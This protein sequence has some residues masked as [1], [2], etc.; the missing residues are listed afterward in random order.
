MAAPP[1]L[2]A[3]WVSAC[4]LVYADDESAL[5]GLARRVSAGG[6]APTTLRELCELCKRW[7]KGFAAPEERDLSDAL[8][9]K[10]TRLGALADAAAAAGRD[11]A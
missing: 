4:V 1:P 9:A 8:L 6:P 7:D 3:Q 2:F 5:A 10:E 11:R